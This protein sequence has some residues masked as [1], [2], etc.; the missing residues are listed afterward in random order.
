MACVKGA[1]E[2]NKDGKDQLAD[3]LEAVE[4]TRR[5]GEERSVCVEVEC[6]DNAVN[7]VSF[8]WELFQTFWYP[9]QCLVK[10]IVG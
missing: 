6:F 8:E 3:G 10:D 9:R 4:R 1:S 7:V 2:V 5:R